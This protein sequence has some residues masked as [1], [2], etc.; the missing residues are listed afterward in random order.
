MAQ[1]DTVLIANRGEIA[2]RIAR[3]AKSLGYASVAVYSEADKGSAHVRAADVAVAIGPAPATQSYLNIE[4]IIDAARR[5]GAQAIHPGYG[6]LA[7][8]AE[9]AQACADAGLAF[10]GPS[11]EA[12]RV[13]GD[14]AESKRRMIAA[15]VPCVPGYNDADQSDEVL[16]AA[17]QDI[18]VPL[19]VKA[20][21]GGGGKGMRFVTDP[22]DIPGAIEAARREALAAFSNDTLILERAIRN[23]RHIEIQV[24]ADSHGNVVHLGERDCSIQR[25]HQK[26]IEEAPAPGVSSEL[27]ETMGRAAVQAAR[28]INYC[29]A[30]TVE[31]L[32]SSDG[33]FYFLEMNT[34]LQVE[35][36]VT[37]MITS[38]DL[39][40][41]QFQVAQ[42]NPLPLTQDQITFDGHAI[43][44]RLYTEMPHKGFMPSTG[45]VLV[46]QAPQGDGI[47]VDH[48]LAAGQEI[49][50][51]YDP[52]VAKIIAYG[53]DREE[54]RRR[55]KTALKKT[56]LLGV[57]TN[58]G[59]LAGL[60]DH[61]AIVNSAA[62]TGF[63]DAEMDVLGLSRPTA[64][65]EQAAPAAVLMLRRDADRLTG[66]APELRDWHSDGQALSYFRLGNGEDRFDLCVT[67]HGHDAY[68]VTLGDQ[69]I[70]LEVVHD[71]APEITAS[72]DGLIRSGAFAFDADQA[73]LL[74]FGGPALRLRDEQGDPFDTTASGVQDLVTAPLHGKVLKLMVSEGQDVTEGT[75]LLIIEAMKME[76]TIV[77]PLA[78]RIA[79]ISTAE[80]QQVIINAQL[81]RFEP[82]KEADQ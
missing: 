3:S 9:F 49:T 13:M 14:K 44:A 71:K 66:I 37:E 40:N 56:V 21:A 63:L 11:P 78:G 32:L 53:S 46:W 2:C 51:F 42:G 54:A 28:T 62:D 70:S 81:I 33:S 12:I 80:G 15:G 75:P 68:S 47:R 16:L 20:A 10:I 39:V 35:H 69:I 45:E 1:F 36:P 57:E 61:P 82:G 67:A 76:H 7:E 4:A 43:E 30:G 8:N 50:S 27:R 41:W 26:V 77:A 31:F 17:A 65:P 29:G 6:F 59:F 60:L 38:Q 5:S 74:Q 79:E 73:V 19:L 23:A 64:N 22:A 24:F 72:I 58:A 48:G 55:L 25:R 34:R 52:M 18:G